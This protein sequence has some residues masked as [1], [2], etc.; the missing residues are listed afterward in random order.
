MGFFDSIGRV[1]GDITGVNASKNQAKATKAQQAI[2][3]LQAD[4][5]KAVQPQY[6][7][8]IE[9][10]AR[11]A[12]QYAPGQNIWNLPEVMG[13]RAQA[14]DEIRSNR[15]RGLNEVYH[16]FARRGIRGPALG[17]AMLDVYRNADTQQAL[18]NRNLDLNAQAERER[19]LGLLMNALNLGFG[20]GSTAADQYGKSAQQY[21]NQAAG[22]QSSLFSLGMALGGGGGKK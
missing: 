1:L 9:Q 17:G 10:L 5:F 15:D 19:R 7:S 4:T 13:Q 14:Y 20:Q 2:S 8:G 11:H 12:G 16:D 21:G 3:R 22:A 6:L 18:F